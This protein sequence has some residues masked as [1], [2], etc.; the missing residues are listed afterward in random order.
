[1]RRPKRAEH[2]IIRNSHKHTRRRVLF[3]IESPNLSKFSCRFAFTFDSRSRDPPHINSLLKN[4]RQCS[5]LS[6]LLCMSTSNVWHFSV[7]IGCTVN[8]C[9]VPCN[10]INVC[11]CCYPRSGRPA[12][13]FV[14]SRERINRGKPSLANVERLLWTPTWWLSETSLTTALDLPFTVIL[15]RLQ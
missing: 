7:V 4:P 11:H 6:F 3:R 8:K 1:M 2:Q 13:T 15:D 12:P 5:R 9:T 14:G 10:A